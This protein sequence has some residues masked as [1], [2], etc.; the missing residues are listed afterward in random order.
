MRR[1]SKKLDRVRHGSKLTSLV[2]RHAKQ[3]KGDDSTRAKAIATEVIKRTLFT[4]NSTIRKKYRTAHNTLSRHKKLNDN[5]CIDR[6]NLAIGLF[7]AAGIRSWV[8]RQVIFEIRGTSGKFMLHDFVEAVIDGKIHTI[9]FGRNLDKD[10]FDIKK[11]PANKVVG[12]GK[13]YRGVD[14]SH[15]GGIRDVASFKT[16]VAKMN[17]KDFFEKENLENKKRLEFMIKEGLI[18]EE[19]ANQLSEH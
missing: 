19:I 2:R 11:G 10:Y 14:S 3:Y 5:I 1:V 9:Y 8:A 18:P 17:R 13:Y 6:C 15:L 12:E 4:P 7:N 16:Y